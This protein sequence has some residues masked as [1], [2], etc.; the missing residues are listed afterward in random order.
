MTAA[1][2]NRLRFV[3]R[4]EFVNKDEQGRYLPPDVTRRVVRYVLQQWWSRAHEGYPELGEWRDVPL[5]AE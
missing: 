3:E 2:T 4:E 5:E 1:P